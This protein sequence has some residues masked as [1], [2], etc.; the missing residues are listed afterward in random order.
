MSFFILELSRCDPAIV[1]G[2][3]LM[4][5]ACT[6]LLKLISYAHTNYDMRALSKSLHKVMHELSFPANYISL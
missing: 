5:F 6:M 2:V 4:L 3:T 1:S